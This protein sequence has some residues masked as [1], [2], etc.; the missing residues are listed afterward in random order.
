MLVSLTISAQT[1]TFTRDDIEFALE[2]PSTRWQ[3]VSR[4]DVHGHVDFI[5]GDNAADGYLRLRKRL[6]STG[7]TA[8]DLFRDDE[9]WELQHLPGYVACGSCEGEPLEDADST[10]VISYEYINAGQLTA[11]RIYYLQINNRVFY[12]LHFTLAQDRLGKI[13]N[14]MDFIARSFHVK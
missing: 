2:L 9:K 11:G 8:G 3:P 7:K 13:R 14:D 4:L 6:V 1:R 10:T 5:F 12:V